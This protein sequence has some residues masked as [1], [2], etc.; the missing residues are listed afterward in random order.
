ME[1]E[2]IKCSGCKCLRH[3]VDE[4]E[5]YKGTRRK[6]C[7]KCKEKRNKN[8][9]P[10]G[11]RKEQC[12]ECGGSRFCEHGKFKSQCKDCGGSQICI[13]KLIKYQ[14]KDCKGSQICKHNIMRNRCAE[15]NPMNHVKHIVNTWPSWHLKDLK[16]QS[17]MKYLGCTSEEFKKYIEGQF[18]EGISWDNYKSHWDVRMKV[19]PPLLQLSEAFNETDQDKKNK[20]IEDLEKYFHYTSTRI[21]IWKYD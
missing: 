14:C 20:K 7:L 2:Y 15:C 4:Y 21:W 8:K 9:C 1:P 19:Q 12:K 10:H 11:K 17:G 3:I 13:H 5:I 18:I 6:N 16:R